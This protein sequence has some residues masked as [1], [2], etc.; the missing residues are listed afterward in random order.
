MW[1]ADT[2]QN[3]CQRVSRWKIFSICSAHGRKRLCDFNKCSE[4]VSLTQ[5]SITVDKDF[6]G[7]QHT[8]VESPQRRVNDVKRKM[9]GSLFNSV[10]RSHNVIPTKLSTKTIFCFNQELFLVYSNS[11]FSALC[12]EWRWETKPVPL[13]RQELQNTVMQTS[14]TTLQFFCQ[15]STVSVNQSCLCR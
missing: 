2:V 3:A 11:K 9:M 1:A 14:T 13:K 12:Y 15:L 7:Q 5:E 8:P 4:L 6:T 10:Y